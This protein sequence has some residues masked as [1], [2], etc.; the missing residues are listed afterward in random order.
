MASNDPPRR[1]AGPTGEPGFS[2]DALSRLE[3]RLERASDAAERLLSD[4]TQHAWRKPPRAGWQQPAS[5]DDGPRRNPGVGGD[6]DLLLGLLHSLGELIPSELQRR[7]ADA[8]REVLLA[9]RA[10]ID[11][12][13]ERS[14]LRHPEPVE[15][16]DIPIM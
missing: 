1:R 5:E 9:L 12:Y 2:E 7:L 11:W 6:I 16:Q 10:L 4:A 3:E 13:L 15:V 8:L 14:A